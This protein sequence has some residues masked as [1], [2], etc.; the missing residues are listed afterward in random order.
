M[1]RRVLITVV[2]IVV[3]GLAGCERE[4]RRFRDTAVTTTH[5]QTVLLT[6]L[7]AGAAPAHSGAGSPFGNNAY[8]ISEGKRLYAAFNCSGC[9]ATAGGGA[10]GPALSDDKWIYGYAPEQ[11]YATIVQGRPNGMPSFAAK[12]PE[13][14]VWQLVAYIE[15]MSAAVPRDAASGRNDDLSAAKGEAR[16]DRIDRRQTGHR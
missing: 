13:Q 7:T 14:Q 8:G 3:V 4:A 10:I 1:T 5:P 2:V 12:L 9:H 16:A 11:I 15:S 6:T